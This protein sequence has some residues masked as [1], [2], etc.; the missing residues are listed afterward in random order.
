MIVEMQKQIDTIAGRI[1]Q[2]PTPPRAKWQ[3]YTKP[4]WEEETISLPRARASGKLK[5]V[6]TSPIARIRLC[7]SGN[8]QFVNSYD[9]SGNRLPEYCG[10]FRDVGMKVLEVAGNLQW[11]YITE[12]A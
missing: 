9:H 12:P 2:V 4:S 10:P 11:E 5:L 8:E 7:M 1:S 6:Q 3:R